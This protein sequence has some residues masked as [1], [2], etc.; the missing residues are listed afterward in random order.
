MTPNGASSNGTSFSCSA[1]GAWSVAMTEI[2]PSRTASSSALRSSAAR[3][4]GFIFRFA[5]SERTA[6]SVSTR[7]CGVASPVA[8]DAGRERMPQRVDRLARREVQQVDR[9]LLVARRARGRVRP[10]RSRPPTGSRRSPSAAETVAL[11]H[12]ARRARASAPRSAAAIRRPVIAWY[13][14]ARRISPGATTGRPSSREPGR[15]RVGELGHL[16]QLLAELALRDRGQ[17]ADRH[18]R[19]LARGL[20]QRAEHRRRV[21]DRLGVR[22]RQ[23]RAVAARGGRSRP[24]RDRL[25]VLAARVCADGR[26][27]R[28]TPGASTSP[29][30]STTRCPFASTFRPICEIT[31]PSTRTSSSSS[32]PRVGSITRALR[33]TRSSCPASAEEHH[34]TSPASSA[35]TS[36]G[37]CVSRS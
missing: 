24:A 23:D 31:P 21:D 25:L 33:T 19:L 36:T 6:S 37:P 11:V 34:A 2:V 1:W 10:S 8:C 35:A 22:H 15:A 17:E 18:L 30:P 13:W 7:W 26:A 20:D 3:S 27:G 14:S 12:L 16:R 28:R 32:I 29:R 5:S 4:G 9:L